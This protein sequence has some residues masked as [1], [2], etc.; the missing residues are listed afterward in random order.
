MRS[1]DEIK[2]AAIKRAV[3]RK[4]DDSILWP[5]G[6]TAECMH[7]IM[8]EELITLEERIKILEQR[9]LLPISIG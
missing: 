5:L 3:D 7:E 6:L 8:L 2:K 4:R 1:Y 9:I